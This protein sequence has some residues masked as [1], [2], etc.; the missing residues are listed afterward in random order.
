[1]PP[2]KP[3]LLDQRYKQKVS[4][5]TSLLNH[6]SKTKGL[7]SRAINATSIL[8]ILGRS[9]EI[10]SVLVFDGLWGA[11]VVGG[12]SFTLSLSINFLRMLNHCSTK[13]N[14]LFSIKHFEIKKIPCWHV[15]LGLT[16]GM[17]SSF[18][19]SG[20]MEISFVQSLDLQDWSV[21]SLAHKLASH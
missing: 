11:L 6:Q 16:R 12:P 18:W 14:D 7:V 21:L 19:E 13:R 9:R 17:R 15:P 1:M 5:S 20:A 10:V 4:P 2:S 8:E 3:S